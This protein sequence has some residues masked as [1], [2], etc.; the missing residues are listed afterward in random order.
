MIAAVVC[1]GL[2]WL[3]YAWWSPAVAFVLFLPLQLFRAWSINS[4]R[5]EACLETFDLA[6]FTVNALFIL[7]HFCY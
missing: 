7:P 5:T 2:G 4:W 3:R 6:D 1:L